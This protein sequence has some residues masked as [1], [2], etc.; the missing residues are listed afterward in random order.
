MQKLFTTIRQLCIYTIEEEG[1][2]WNHS[3]TT[4][5]SPMSSSRR[6]GGRRTPARR[7]TCSSSCPRGLS[8]VLFSLISVIYLQ[9]VSS[10]SPSIMFAANRVQSYPLRSTV[11]TMRNINN[12]TTG[13]KLSRT[14]ASSLSSSDH[15]DKQLKKNSQTLSIIDDYIQAIRPLTIV[16]AVGALVVGR[17]ALMSSGGG[18]DS[19]SSPMQMLAAM[20]SVYLSYGAG[21]AM[22][23]CADASADAQH[24]IKQN[25][26]IAA[27]RISPRNGWIFCAA[28]SGL[29]LGFGGYYI[30]SAYSIWTASNLLLMLGYALGL[31]RLF[32]VKNILCGWFAIS[33][34]VGA[35]LMTSTSGYG[36][37]E[38]CTNGTLWRLAGVG[39]PVQV[40]REI[41]KDVEDV[42]I[43][44]DVAHKLTLPLVI[45]DIWA[46]RIAYTLVAAVC[47]T[48][49]FT[50]PYWKL[51]ASTPPLYAIG[52]CVGVPMCI[53]S[54]ML[55]LKKGEQ[56]L[57][58]SV[59][60]LLAGMIGGLMMQ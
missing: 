18:H 8:I 1:G 3:E 58:K 19:S 15:S 6:G 46:H 11:R 2:G 13:R 48:M 39:F 53:R 35:A 45:G 16:Q 36:M 12:T 10:F 54:S 21:M 28:L 47:S 25:R 50:K 60:V 24:S 5:C 14:F 22:N 59:Y 33:P 51:F 4:S 55:P 9:H 32:L 7:A 30:G 40:A 29:S 57:K 37:K 23:D 42:D 31:Q 41:L 20:T 56:L 26:A 52:V 27:G 38:L 44:R 43:D 49:V 17:L 34:L